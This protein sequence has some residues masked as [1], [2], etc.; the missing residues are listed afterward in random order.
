MQ[1]DKTMMSIF[2]AAALAVTLPGC[3]LGA[4]A[5]AGALA[6]DEYNEAKECDDGFD[7]LE[8]ARNSGDGCN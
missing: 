8:N 5:G 1:N 3:A 2:A 4:A 7:P 6:A